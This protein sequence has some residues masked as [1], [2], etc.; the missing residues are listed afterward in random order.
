M[1]F[2]PLSRLA[3]LTFLVVSLPS[4]LAFSFT[5]TTPT[6]CSDFTVSWYERSYQPILSPSDILTG[7]VERRRFTSSWSPYVH[8]FALPR[9]C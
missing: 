7:P 8:C 4:S 3:A 9:D 6:Q 5:T 2:S 1:I